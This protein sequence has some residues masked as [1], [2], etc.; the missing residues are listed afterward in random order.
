MTEE[1]AAGTATLNHAPPIGDRENR[2]FL[3]AAL[4]NGLIQTVA[5]DRFT[6]L[7]LSLPLMWLG[8]SGRGYPIE[9]LAE[10]MSLGP[11]RLAGLTRKGSIE[12]GY[13]ADLVIFDPDADVAPH[14][15]QRH[16]GRRRP[17]GAVERTYLR[18]SLIYSRADGWVSEP[19]GNLMMRGTA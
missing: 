13:D 18:G 16:Y 11:A 1:L 8:A 14:E 2:E 3:W 19:R 4:A 10:W 5:A 15:H 12:V 17:R 6:P 7:E 9:R